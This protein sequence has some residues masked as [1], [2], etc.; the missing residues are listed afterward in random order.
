MMR[1]AISEGDA[2]AADAVSSAARDG[3]GGRRRGR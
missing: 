1:V 3:I 2:A